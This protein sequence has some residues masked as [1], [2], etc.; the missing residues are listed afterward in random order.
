MPATAD[1]VIVGAG[2]AGCVLAERLSRNP[3]RRV[4]LLERGTAATPG[5]L[6]ELPVAAGNPQ[7]IAVPEQRGRSVMRGSAIGGSAVINGGYFLRW[8]REDFAEWPTGWELPFVETAYRELDGTGQSDWGTMGAR[9]YTDD[10]LGDVPRAFEAY[11][12]PRVADRSERGW[13]VVGL[14]R[15]RAN[16]DEAGNRRTAAQAY[17]D[18]ARPRANL[19]VHH[20]QAYWLITDGRTVTGVV[21]DVGEI[22]AGEVILCAGTLGTAEILMRTGTRAAAPERLQL[23]EHAEGLVTFT[24]TR[25]LQR[26]PL[27]QTVVHTADG[28]EFRCYSDDF[29]AYTPGLPRSGVPIGVAAMTSGTD[30]WVELADDRLRLDLGLPDAAGRAAIDAG[31]AQIRDMLADAAFAGLVEP[32]SITVHP[33][34]GTSQHAWGTMPMGERVDWLGAVEGLLGLRIVDG[35][36]LPTAGR[37]GPHETILMLACVIGDRLAAI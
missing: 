12:V 4:V 26:T 32:G 31:V 21:T 15:V 17:L 6:T 19:T 20:A 28:L 3:D 10:E 2:S 36:I 37:S 5:P 1:V 23:A 34:L 24:P 18:P 16:R 7:A 25:P 11:W 22:S 27:L 13:P 30:G 8:H 14:N 35:S 29:A 33:D 9:P